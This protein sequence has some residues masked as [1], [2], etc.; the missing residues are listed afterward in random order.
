[1]QRH[2]TQSILIAF[3]L[4]V[5]SSTTATGQSQSAIVEGQVVDASGAAV[6][7]AMLQWAGVGV[8]GG[9]TDYSDSLGN[10]AFEM[11]V[12]R[13]TVE[14]QI[15]L[16]ANAYLPKQVSVQAQGGQTTP[17]QIV[18]Q[19]K[20]LNQFATVKGSLVD[21]KSH[22]GIPAAE[23]QILGAG[24]ILKS[25]TDSNGEFSIGGV[26]YN[27]ALTLQAD[28]LEYPCIPVSTFPLSVA[29]RKVKMKLSAAT[30]IIETPHCPN[31]QGISH[32]G[33]APEEA[34]QIGIDDTLQWTQADTLSISTNSPANAWNAGRVN[35]IL[36][37][38]AGTGL[39][40][41]SDEGGV[42][43]I[44]ENGGK[45]A[46]P[47]GNA[48]NSITMASLAYGPGGSSDVYGGTYDESPSSPGHVL[49]E[50]DT[51]AGFPLLNWYPVNNAPP[52]ST[53]QRILV[54]AEVGRIVLA[55]NE[56]LFW[57]VIPPSPSV[58][59]VY[60]WHPAD[61]T[62]LATKAF[63]G[64]TK[65]TGWIVGSQHEGTIVATM[66]GGDAPK[67]LIVTAKWQNGTLVLKPAAVAIGNGNTFGRTSVAACPKNPNFMYA[68]AADEK[69]DHI[70]GVWESTDGGFT[71]S[72]RNMPSSAGDQ[73][74]FYN[75]AI[76]VAPD[77]SSIAV[78]WQSGT[79]LS[80]DD[81]GSW[82]HIDD[83]SGHQHADI[84]ALTYDPEDPTVLFIGS[85]GGVMA[86]SGIAP[87]VQPVLESD[88]SRELLNLEFNPGA[89]STSFA[90]LVTGAAQ[91]N[92]SLY[93][94]VPGSPWQH[95]SSCGCD[96][97]QSFFATPPGIAPANDLL[98]E[99]EWGVP[100]WPLDSVETV[101]GFVPYS[102]Q[103]DIPIDHDNETV[104]NGVAQA[105]RSPGGFLNG[106]GEPMIA[107]NGNSDNNTLYGLFSMPDGSD[108]HWEVIGQLGGPETISAVGPAADGSSVF[109][110]TNAGNIYLFSAPYT[111]TGT[112][113]NVTPPQAGGA[114][115]TGL[116]AFFSSVAW[117]SYNVGNN[118]YVMF[119][120]GSTWSAS[121]LGVLPN[122]LPFNSIAAKD[123]NTIFVSS[124][125]AVYDS[126]DAG[127]S[128][129]YANVGLPKNITH[130]PQLYYLPPSA[131]GPAALYLTTWGRSLW[132]TPIR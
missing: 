115:V 40:L 20:P 75:N 87:N 60:N 4:A 97:G 109:V 58:Y 62:A 122:S 19:P 23:I 48:W 10:F 59:G 82:M 50:T 80:F 126:R 39:V 54:I 12:A 67:K 95:I 121:G 129:S 42:W 18:V 29:T 120:N 51:S 81:A 70:G 25:V 72:S 101:S 9:G 35:D 83:S 105:V 125:V 74:G 79:W 6:P 110:G 112:Q 32:T 89:A 93:A 64:L 84:H 123:L 113:L 96:G 3:V 43:L 5:L 33:G 130:K 28:T 15:A 118:G 128:W 1:M 31:N 131:S 104:N 77:C 16:V 106:S 24:G 111:G 103:K 45:S 107:V 88:W 76:A 37:G 36:R 7:N 91:D 73:Q 65:G 86:A 52:C 90:G 46:I 99:R 124:S 102:Q 127:A 114:S 17:V 116:Y 56:G 30:L 8:P 38:P 2:T 26:G 94:D 44:A 61:P 27:T 11:P 92:G 41:A 66:N 132:T 57:S 68:L 108:I 34:P 69:N 21:S 98:I 13:G 49:W 55:C 71:W 63:S 100:N 14:V 22:Q 78:G 117:A 85:D 53:I 47:A 119:W